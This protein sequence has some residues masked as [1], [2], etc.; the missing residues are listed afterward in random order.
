MQIMLHL[1]L[2]V[3]S[4]N[5]KR[6]YWLF[7]LIFIYHFLA[8]GWKHL[9]ARRPR[10][11][12]ALVPEKTLNNEPD[13]WGYK[14]FCRAS[15][16]GIIRDFYHG[17]ST[18]F[19]AALSEQEQTLFLGAKVVSTPCRIIKQPQLSVVFCDRGCVQVE[20]WKMRGFPV[21]EHINQECFIAYKKDRM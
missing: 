18:F 1:N 21:F 15:S 7:H 16:S 19:I 9:V 11:L 6:D 3:S 8:R 14:L 5:Y 10:T 17:A 2:Q 12:Q 13:K 20:M 4:R